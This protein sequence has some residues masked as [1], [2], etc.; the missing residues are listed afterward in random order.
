[1]VG[2]C[3]SNYSKEVEKV[4][5]LFPR[6]KQRHGERNSFLP[7]LTKCISLQQKGPSEFGVGMI[8]AQLL[9]GKPGV[10]LCDSVCRP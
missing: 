6:Q 3:V 8:R 1:M 7:A 4:T 9:S 10:V 5:V 2:E